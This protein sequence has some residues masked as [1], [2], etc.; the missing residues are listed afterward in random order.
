MCPTRGSLR[1]GNGTGSNDPP[2]LLPTRVTT[3]I[4]F[5]AV[6]GLGP[7]CGLALSGSAYCWGFVSGSFNTYYVAPGDC[8]TAYYGWYQGRQC[9]VPTP[10]ATDLRF[11]SLAGERCGVTTGGDAYCWGDGFY[12][13][14]GDGR[15]AVYSVTPVRVNGSIKFAQLTA[16][17]THV[18]GLDLSGKAYCWGNN[19]VGQLGIGDHGFGRHYVVAEPTP[20]ATSVPFTAIVAG[21][22]H[23]CGMTSAG[24]V[25]CWGTN[26]FGELG[27]GLAAGLSDVPVLVQLPPL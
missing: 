10:I 7:N 26:D 21:D 15:T 9:L 18:C 4:R 14:F 25:W 19:F 27:P 6:Y 2:V 17:A 12:G 13:T 16:G 20:V 23:T 1:L 3:R 8:T 5:R 22:A 11:A 24:Q